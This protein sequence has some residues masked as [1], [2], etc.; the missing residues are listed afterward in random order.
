MSHS[1]SKDFYRVLQVKPTA[2]KL[3]IKDAYRKLALAL[4][5]DR[6]DGCDIKTREFKEASEAYRTLSDHETRKQYD[7]VASSTWG[8]H[9]KYGSGTSDMK[10]KA[11]PPNYRKVYSPRAP[12][13]M[14]TFDPKKHYE[15]H[16]GEGMMKEEV[17]RARRRAEKASG[18]LSGFE[19]ESPLGKGFTF[20]GSS[21]GG[22]NTN[23]Y[24]KRSRQGP[25]PPQG[26]GGGDIEYE[27]V[28]YFDM[29]SSDATSAKRVI[30]SR[31]IVRE[32]VQERRNNRT[33]PEERRQ[34]QQQQ[35]G[36]TIM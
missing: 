19:Y 8:G 11:P 24:S 27:E 9:F 28:H 29:N 6:H 14:K 25:P 15:M 4:H 22:A 35:E 13:G 17:E 12:K 34:H 21:S 1:K 26:G 36:C 31:E 16:Y 7:N 2:S 23:P 10:P 20:S 30:R 5:P 3:E 18:R 33:P 32:R